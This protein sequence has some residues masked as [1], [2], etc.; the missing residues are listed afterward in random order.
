MCSPGSGGHHG[1]CDCRGARMEGF[2]QPCLLLLL[3]A[4]PTHGYELMES[5]NR[6]GLWS[7]VPDAGAVYRNLRRLEEDGLVHSRWSTSGPG[8]ARRLYE[9]TQEG[10]DYLHDWVVT[11]R[12]NKA[13]LATFLNR[14]EDLFGPDKDTGKGD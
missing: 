5:M 9:I 7:G 10:L 12:R 13:T 11:I 8:P 3:A 14:Y 2:L 1:R 6:L 4:K